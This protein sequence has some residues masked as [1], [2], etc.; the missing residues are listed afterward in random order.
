MQRF[1]IGVL[2]GSLLSLFLPA[3]PLFFT[4]ILL[5]A[6][7]ISVYYRYF[8]IVGLLTFVTC[9][10]WQ[11]YS[12][13]Q[14]QSQLLS[15]PP[16]YLKVQVSSWQK[17]HSGDTLV[18]FVLVEGAAKGYRI[19]IRWRGANQI[20]SG[21]QW[22]LKLRLS[23]PRGL[24]N[25][26]SRQRDLQALLEGIVAFGYVMPEQPTILLKDAQDQRQ[27]IIQQLTAWTDNLVTAPLLQALTVGERN[28]SASLWL[29]IQHS[30]LGHILTI[31]GLHIGLVFGWGYFIT[32]LL[33]RGQSLTQR[34]VYQLLVGMVAALAYAWLAG[35]AIPTIRAA[36]ALVIV[37]MSRLLLRPLSGRSAWQLLV[38]ILLLINPFWVLSYSFWLS[39]L[40]VAVIIFFAWW[41]PSMPQQK[42]AKLGYILVFHFF[43]TLTMSLISMA[44]FSGFSFLALVSNV[45]FVTWCSLVAIPVLLFTLCWSLLAFPFANYLWQVSHQL[46]LPLWYWLNW[47]SEHNVWWSVPQ[48][49]TASV[50]LLVATFLAVLALRLAWQ[51]M[52]IVSCVLIMSVF[53][54]TYRGHQILL[55]NSGQS[56][57][58][59]LQ[60]P[61]L[62][63]LYLD[64]AETQL[65]ALV[66][67]L[68]LPQLRFHRVKRL[69]FILVPNLTAEMHA[70]IA[71]LKQYQPDLRVYSA[72]AQPGISQPCRDLVTNF[73]NHGIIH[74]QLPTADPCLVSVE[75]AGW[76]ILLPGNLRQHQEQLIR[77]RYPEIQ[78]DLYLLADYGRPSANSLDWI[79]HISPVMLLLSANEHGAYQYPL[80]SVQQRIALLGIP[81]Y[82]AGQQGALTVIFEE[83]KLNI[84]AE[85][86]QK[87]VPWLEKSFH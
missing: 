68:L 4:I 74:W 27:W 8:T 32:G 15:Q 60:Q 61:S 66:Q 13:Q 22:Q 53:M 11:L 55:L 87:S 34:N 70:A 77:R 26:G 72:M 69:D 37:I 3:L 30:G 5:L 62:N 86:Q 80:S 43:L 16:Q 78:T 35:F 36:S 76:R 81:L 54:P 40:A 44:F 12:Y 1:C 59:I 19:Q 85:R 47:S 6:I 31:S 84:L 29:G 64:A 75:L 46:F 67:H 52:L 73:P 18:N 39:V 28:F 50:L 63:W 17:L 45:V 21:Q 25:P 83:D 57:L 14:A 79:A 38:A 42:L 58:L 56:T 33:L 48:L 10:H 65:E 7:I 82:H 51:G 9:W 41:L 24:I 2:A 20:I 49:N 23:K 71:L